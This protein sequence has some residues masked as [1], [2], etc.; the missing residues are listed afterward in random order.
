VAQ[1]A[2]GIA[3]TAERVQARIRFG[4]NP[5]RIANV[6]VLY[7]VLILIAVFFLMP[8][9]WMVSTSL[10][11]EAGVFTD[12]GVVPRNPTLENFQY[13]LTSGSDTPV[14]R[15]LLNSAIVSVV[16]TAMTVLLTSLSAYAFARME[17]PGKSV[18][19]WL[20]IATLLLPSVMFLVP[21]FVVIN[22]IGLFNSYPAFILPG[23]GGVFGVFFM[24]QFFMGIPREMEEAAFMDGAG[25]LRIFWTIVLPLCGPAIATLAVISFLAYWN[26]YLWPLIVCQGAGCTLPPGLRNLQG[27]Y[28]TRYG[29]I[30]AG[31]VLSSLPVLAFYLLVQRWIIQSVATAGIKG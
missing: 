4:G 25:R 16:G 9:I 1:A 26:D 15:W 30:M 23:L 21:Q 3:R 14:F 20:M 24:R 31:A 10:K 13:L 22:M 28:V 5:G 7:A 8:L 12:P 27:E 6:G 17:F 19:F 11:N 18:L 2:G 29:L